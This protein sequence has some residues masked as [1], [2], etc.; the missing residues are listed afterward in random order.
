MIS[1]NWIEPSRFVLKN[2][3][4]RHCNAG[5][6]QFLDAVDFLAGLV[7]EAREFE[8]PAETSH[9]QLTR[10]AVLCAADFDDRRAHEH[11]IHW[12]PGWLGSE[13][14]DAA[15]AFQLAV[16]ATKEREDGI[17][18]ELVDRLRR[19]DGDV[20]KT[21]KAEMEM[22]TEKFRRLLNMQ[23]WFWEEHSIV[24]RD[25]LGD[26]N[27]GVEMLMY[28]SER[29]SHHLRPGEEA[30]RH[31]LL[32]VMSDYRSQ[33]KKFWMEVRHDP[34]WQHLWSCFCG[35]HM[36][37]RAWAKDNLKK[38]ETTPKKRKLDLGLPFTPDRVAEGKPG[39]LLKGGDIVPTGFTVPGQQPGSAEE[40]P[41]REAKKKRSGKRL[42][43]DVS[44]NYKKLSSRGFTYRTWLASHPNT[45]F[46]AMNRESLILIKF[47][48]LEWN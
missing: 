34:R 4:G 5:E 36:D 10:V 42:P 47:L 12:V 30:S 9:G 20:S 29:G 37:L 3:C 35:D 43:F 22:V 38:S 17:M 7:P 27:C 48:F 31:D 26:G 40:D 24:V 19:V 14:E 6:K 33:L 28:F 16:T 25:V 44:I 1:R 23:C 32:P 41:T 2:H 11:C 45:V 39:K 13:I 21:V 8:L 15:T 46:L 18:D